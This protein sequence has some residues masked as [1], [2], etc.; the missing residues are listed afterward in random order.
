MRALPTPFF[1]DVSGSR[2]FAVHHAPDSAVDTWGHILCVP[3]F[4]EEMNR[5]RS[6]LTLQAR[7]LA[8]QGVGTLLVDLHGTGESDGVHGDARWESWR[9]DIAAGIDWLDGQRGGC[10]G[11]LGVRLGVALA[12]EALGNT[13]A[14]GRALIA[15]QPVIDGKN[16]L[17][18]FMR[19][20]IAGN[21]DRTDI[22]KETTAD[23]RHALAAGRPIEI[24]GY[25][26]Q[27][28]LASAIEGCRLSQT[29][30]PPATPIAWFEKKTGTGNELPPASTTVIEQ[31]RSCGLP[32]TAQ[33]FDGPPFWAVHDRANAP[34]LIEQTTAWVGGL[35]DTR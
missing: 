9:A 34:A 27:P 12:A 35:R 11:L 8:E 21:M 32:V 5:C 17:T 14:T 6:M 23:M 33:V 10:I 28:A 22:P 30:P 29:V 7:A 2:R 15:W 13:P 20:R 1:L 16:Y 4:N 25:E 3:A 31:W 19:M 18:Q 24:A 26:I